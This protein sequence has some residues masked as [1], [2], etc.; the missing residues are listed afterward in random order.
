MYHANQLQMNNYYS[1]LIQT[2]DNETQY[3][4]KGKIFFTFSD[5]LLPGEI[6]IN[7]FPQKVVPYV[8]PV[9]QCHNCLLFRQ[10]VYA[11]AKRNRQIVEVYMKRKQNSILNAYIIKVINVNQLIGKSSLNLLDKKISMAFVNKFYCKASLLVP[12]TKKALVDK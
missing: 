3:V 2:I 4:P 9:I 5:R 1:S 12:Q 10:V 7:N 6:S 8:G 11:G